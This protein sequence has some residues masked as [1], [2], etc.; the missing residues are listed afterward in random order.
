[1]PTVAGEEGKALRHR[2]FTSGKLNKLQELSHKLYAKSDKE[3]KDFYAADLLEITRLTTELNDLQPRM[4]AF[5]KT[6][7][8][9]VKGLEGH[10]GRLAERLA[11]GEALSNDERN[12]LSAALAKEHGLDE[13]DAFTMQL[14]D[15]QHTLRMSKDPVEAF[16]NMLSGEFV[17][18]AL[19][20]GRAILTP[21]V[22]R[23]MSPAEKALL[24]QREKNKGSGKSK[25][26]VTIQRIEVQS[27]DPDR[28]VFG[29]VSAFSDAAK[30]PSSALDSFAE[31]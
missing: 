6:L 4:Q 13:A 15:L 5:Y 11:Q 16:S 19:A 10:A 7:S 1:M 23:E 27:D 22:S 28:F 29:M 25:V 30:N 2:E 9:G 3:R 26:N 8:G 12:E 14:Q 31:G 20:A 21:E 18:A 17:P 24:A